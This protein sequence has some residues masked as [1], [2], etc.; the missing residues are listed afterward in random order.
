MS[1]LSIFSSYQALSRFVRDKCD[2]EQEI[3]SSRVDERWL[4]DKMLDFLNA[5]NAR[6]TYQ[7]DTFVPDEFRTGRAGGARRIDVVGSPRRATKDGGVSLMIEVKLMMENNRQW[8]QEVLSDIFRVACARK[9]TTSRTHRLVLVAGQ[10]RCWRQLEDQCGGLVRRLCPMDRRHNL[11]TLGLTNKRRWTSFTDKWRATNAD[12][13]EDYLTPHL[14][15]GVS[16]E[17]AGLSR[18][19][20]DV[21]EHPDRG[22]TARLWRV[23]PGRCNGAVL[24]VETEPLPMNCLSKTEMND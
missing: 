17:L 21:D 8:A 9:Q 2:S 19:H 11:L 10:E 13:L 15:A 7:F 3:E 12:H 6:Q 5:R 23:L 1:S 20:R 16:I 14:P 22:I 24:P 4:V 18:S